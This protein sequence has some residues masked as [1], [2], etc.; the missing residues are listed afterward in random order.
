MAKI[1]IAPKFGSFFSQNNCTGKK[2]FNFKNFTTLV[3]VILWWRHQNSDITRLKFLIQNIK[4]GLISTS[5]EK[6]VVN[7]FSIMYT[8][9]V[10]ITS[11]LGII[12]WR[13]QDYDV[14][15][16]KFSIQNIKNGLISTSDE[17]WGV[18]NFTIMCS[19]RVIIISG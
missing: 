4:I 11:V 3:L 13:H 10:I 8:S 18:I 1:P 6:W 19:S 17:K 12:W 15:W 5:D 9:R 14:T 7:R 2:H 16:L